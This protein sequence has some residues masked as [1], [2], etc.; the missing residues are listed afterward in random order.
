SRRRLCGQV[1]LIIGFGAIGQRC[2]SLLAALGMV[3][4][5]LRRRAQPAS[6]P[7]AR[8]FTAAERLEAVALADHIVCVLPAD[9]GTDHLLDAA[10]FA[11]MKPSAVVYNIGRGNAIDAEALRAALV[12]RR[13]AGAFLDVV[14]DEP[15]PASSPLWSTP[16]LYLT[17]HASA[18]G[19]DY[20][21][22]YFDELASELVRVD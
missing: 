9:T 22:L 20:L 15:L 16:N 19:A 17:P 5:G 1:V 10:A 8:L 13:I 4:H 3:V 14:P 2:G 6:P 18:I 7:A 21:D 11:A 12:E